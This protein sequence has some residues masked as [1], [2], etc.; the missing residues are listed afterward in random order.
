MEQMP[1]HQSLSIAAR[2]IE[3]YQISRRIIQKGGQQTAHPEIHRI[4]R[5]T[6]SIMH[7]R[8]HRAQRTRF[9]RLQ[10]RQDRG[11]RDENT[12]KQLAHFGNRVELNSLPALTC[13]GVI[14]SEIMVSTSKITSRTKF[15]KA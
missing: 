11:N 12:Q 4:N 6:R 2:H 15:C 1:R 8:Y 13:L 14:S 3:E 7:Q 9:P 10:N 5:I